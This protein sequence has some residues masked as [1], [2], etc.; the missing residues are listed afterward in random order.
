MYLQNVL[1]TQVKTV[2]TGTKAGTATW[3][4]DRTKKTVNLDTPVYTKYVKVVGDEAG[5]NFGSAAM[6]EFYERLNSDNYDINKDNSVDNK[7][8]ALLLKYVMGVNLS[9]DI[10]FENADFN[11]DGNID[12][13]D[14]IT[15]KNY[16]DNNTVETTTETTETTTE[17]Q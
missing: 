3:A 8:V 6:I 17:Q 4:S 12:M 5:A 10:S 15:L 11:G 16:T 2:Q 7:D 14:V 13:L 9:S 1:Y